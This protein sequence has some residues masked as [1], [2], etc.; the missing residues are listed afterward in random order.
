MTQ[1]L[2]PLPPRCLDNVGQPLLLT[3]FLVPSCKLISKLNPE[4]LSMTKPRGNALLKE[5]VVFTAI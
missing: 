4:D 2:S 3:Y 5:N 1:A